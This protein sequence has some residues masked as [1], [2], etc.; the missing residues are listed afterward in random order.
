MGMIMLEKLNAIGKPYS[1]SY[2]P[3]YRLKHVVST[4]HLRWPYLRMKFVGEEL[5]EAS[6]HRQQFKRRESTTQKES[7]ATTSYWKEN[8]RKTEFTA[9]APLSIG[10]SYI[11]SPFLNCWN[12]DYREKRGRSRRQL[13]FAHTLDE[14][15]A[16]AQADSK[17]KE[18]AAAAFVGVEK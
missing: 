5:R 17:S 4:A 8:T 2:D 15:K 10:G 13:G 14:A 3:N 11:L 7:T 18:A 12:I 6:H 1:A 16:I 9:R